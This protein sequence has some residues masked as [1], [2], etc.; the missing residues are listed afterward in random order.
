MSL[1]CLDWGGVVQRNDW[2]SCKKLIFL[3]IAIV[4]FEMSIPV[5]LLVH[6]EPLLLCAGFFSFVF[7][8]CATSCHVYP[9]P[10][11]T[12]GPQYL[13]LCF[14]SSEIWPRCQTL[15]EDDGRG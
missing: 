1:L 7:C 3:R 10:S 9:L 8:F 6:P 4:F 12:R 13:C 14:H 11:L 5:S 15:P 2:E